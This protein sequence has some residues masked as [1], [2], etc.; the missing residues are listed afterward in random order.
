VIAAGI[1][2]G[3]ARTL[4]DARGRDVGVVGADL[5]AAGR[6]GRRAERAVVAPE[7]AVEEIDGGDDADLVLVVDGA[8]EAEAMLA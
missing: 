5:R 3:L 1:R 6:L 2:R 7:D 8:V 4:R